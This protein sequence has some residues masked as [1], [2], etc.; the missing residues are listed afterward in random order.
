MK[1]N[2]HIKQEHTLSAAGNPGTGNNPMKTYTVALRMTQFSYTTVTVVAAHLIEA[3]AKADAVQVGQIRKW[4]RSKGYI[5][6][7]FIEEAQQGEKGGKDN[8]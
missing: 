5:D 7:D 6:V 3:M 8:E 2:P 4:S 1:K